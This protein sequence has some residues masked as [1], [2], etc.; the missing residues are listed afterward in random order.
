VTRSSAVIVEFHSGANL[1]A[2]LSSFR[3]DGVSDIVVVNNGG[4]DL[5]TRC[6]LSGV[7]LANT[8]HNLGYGRGVNRGVAL[9]QRTEFLCVSNPDVVV[10][11]G[12]MAA[13]EGYL[14]EHAEV[15][16]VG[17]TI[18]TQ[19]GFP[20]PSV[21]VFPSALVAAMHAVCA[22]WWPGNPWTRRYRSP[23]ADGGVDWVSGAMFLMRRDLFEALGGF[24][25]RYFMFAEDMDLCW[26]AQRHGS[27]VAWC[28][29]AT[30]THVEGASRAAAPREMTRAHH[31][32]AMR[33][34][35]TTSSGWR[36]L[37]VPVA[38]ALLWLRMRVALV[39]RR[40]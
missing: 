37:G 8:G 38:L 34:E 25:E 36:R 17:P 32:S 35:W 13:L 6:D 30:I 33:F 3:E 1:Q 19:E 7:T 4:D 21:R 22:P 9:T 31:R 39:R 26:R 12:A 27:R 28:A 20:Y 5:S 23:R 2:A 40:A 16:I 14:D 24:D 18:V 29:E 11:P 15:G 10:H